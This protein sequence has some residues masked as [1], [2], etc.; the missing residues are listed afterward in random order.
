M[1]EFLSH[2]RTRMLSISARTIPGPGIAA[3]RGV[4]ALSTAACSIIAA[5]SRVPGALPIVQGRQIED[6]VGLLPRR[7]VDGHLVPGA[8][9]EEAARQGRRDG[10][11]SVGGVA[12][13]FHRDLELNLLVVRGVDDTEPRAET[14]A[15]LGDL[16]DPYQGDLRELQLE[17]P[18]ARLHEALALQRRV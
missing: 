1:T 5:G 16:V 10:D 2:C 8:L 17:L 13:P 15:I 3:C 18:D 12:Q 11:E 4:S 7:D 14:D 6:L 9:V